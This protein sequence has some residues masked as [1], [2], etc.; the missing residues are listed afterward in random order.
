[1]KNQKQY[2]EQEDVCTKCFS[3]SEPE[4]APAPVST[5]ESD[6]QSK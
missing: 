4:R 1:M 5:E 6:R 3:G 2:N